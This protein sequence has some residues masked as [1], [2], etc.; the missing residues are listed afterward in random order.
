MCLWN[1][2][3]KKSLSLE[4][5][6][7]ATFPSLFLPIKD[8]TF[9]EEEGE[10]GQESHESSEIQLALVGEY[11]HPWYGDFEIS[12]K[13]LRDFLFRNKLPGG[14]DRVLE[15]TPEFWKL[16]ESAKSADC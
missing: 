3:A 1:F 8:L 12:K 10:E 2:S 4:A 5:P 6:P 14:E 16:I 9:Q 7:A 13:H 11:E 15:E